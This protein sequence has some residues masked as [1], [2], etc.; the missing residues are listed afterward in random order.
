M[1]NPITPSPN[2]PVPL[3]DCILRDGWW[4]VEP[5]GGNRPVELH[6]IAG[7]KDEGRIERHHSRDYRKADSLETGR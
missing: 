1:R 2:R 6:V 7:A 5:C 3:P 4:L